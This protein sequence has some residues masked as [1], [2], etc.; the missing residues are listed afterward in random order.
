MG[1]ANNDANVMAHAMEIW[2]EV[3]VFMALL[4]TVRLLSLKWFQNHGDKH[5][6]KAPYGA[7]CKAREGLG[8]VLAAKNIR[9]HKP[10]KFL[11]GKQIKHLGSSSSF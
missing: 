2:E 11:M 6:K 1:V 3:K 7:C 8:F 5:N 10:P 9:H 4:R